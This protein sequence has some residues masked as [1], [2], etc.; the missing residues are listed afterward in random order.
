MG[1]TQTPGGDTFY[2]PYDARVSPD[3]TRI[4][5]WFGQYTQ[6]YS[7]SC[8]C[9]L[10]HVESYSAWT[11]NDHFTD[12]SEVGYA[13]GSQKPSWLDGNHLLIGVSGLPDAASWQLGGNAG[14]GWS[15]FW[16]QYV[17]EGVNEAVRTRDTKRVAA[18]GGWDTDGQGGDVVLTYTTNGPA[19]TDDGPPWDPYDPF[20]PKPAEPTLHC[21][22]RGDGNQRYRGISWSP[23]G[24]AFTVVQQDG[25]HLYRLP[26][27]SD[28]CGA[29]TNTLLVPG[30]TDAGLG[31]CRREPGPGP[32]RARTDRAAGAARTACAV[33]AAGRPGAARAAVDRRP[34]GAALALQ[35]VRRGVLRLTLS[36]PARLTLRIQRQTS[37]GYR[38][39]ATR[40]LAGKPG[41]N[42]LRL[43]KLRIGR[44]RLTLVAR[45]PAGNQST[46]RAGLRVG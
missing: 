13:I 21:E 20:R 11:Y 19:W 31:P 6:Y 14:D 12:P 27:D 16:F 32:G 7:S 41:S 44:Y 18:I 17:D 39:V 15:Q 38:A 22:L 28:A 34:R 25:V 23:Q 5:Y 36:E 46:A 33:A 1:S 26:I 42:G 3:G 9:W 37:H 29:I 10:W 4:A 35:G 2:G 8:G 30:G 45:D 43:P 24:D 40:T